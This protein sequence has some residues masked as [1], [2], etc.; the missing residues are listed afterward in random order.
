MHNDPRG[1]IINQG[2]IMR[3]NN[4]F[5]EKASCFNNFSGYILVSY[6]APGMNN[7]VSIKKIRLNLNR[8][9]T[10]V[11][12][13]GQRQCI[14]CIRRGMWVNAVFSPIMTRSIPP[15]SN[16]FLIAVQRIPRPPL[17]PQNPSSVT[18]GR[19]VLTDVD[20]NYFITQNNRN[21]QT[22]FMITST[23]S[24]TNRQ[25]MPIRFS[26]LKTGQMVRITHANFQ[27]LSIPPQTTAFNVQLI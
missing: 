25:G 24:F 27:T 2:N 4:A 10:V 8:N 15:Q 19:I 3:I 9:T 1:T 5:V 23:T 22:K 21:D 20:N 13:F 6:S 18:T 26:N 7:T 17:F 14:C 16:A 11:D 12:D